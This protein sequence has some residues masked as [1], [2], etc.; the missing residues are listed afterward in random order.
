MNPDGLNK[1][2]VTYTTD[3][4]IIQVNEKVEQI[5]NSEK[6]AKNK[7]LQEIS[8]LTLAARSTS[9]L[10]QKSNYLNKIAKL[11][12]QLKEIESETKIVKYQHDVK[13]MIEA[14]KALPPCENKI[15]FVGKSIS[16]KISPER[17]KIIRQFFDVVENY[18]SINV[19]H[20]VNV[21]T[22][23]SNCN[24]DIKNL[25]EPVQGEILECP[26]CG[27]NLI[28]YKDNTLQTSTSDYKD[29]E[30]FEKMFINYQGLEKIIFPNSLFVDL[31]KYYKSFDLPDGK[32]V[33]MRKAKGELQDLEYQSLLTALQKTKYVMYYDHVWLLANIYWGMPLA[34]IQNYRDRLM[35]DY[36]ITESVFKIIKG[37]RKASISTKWRLQK[38]LKMRGYHVPPRDFKGVETPDILEYYE[39]M[40]MQMCAGANDPEIVYIP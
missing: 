3:C 38:Q 37:D 13:P 6:N 22:N 17:M 12:N 7:I 33:K 18:I 9:I 14:Y 16:E 39:Q 20:K 19:H 28:S 15:S 4:N 36:D 2:T 26:G 24:I 5:I 30:N 8:K 31:D 10:N 29:R 11:N 25:S 1:L 35:R 21:S 23:C 40:W 34:D 27:L 32:T